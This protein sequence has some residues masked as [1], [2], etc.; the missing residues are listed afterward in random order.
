M[1]GGLASVSVVHDSAMWADGYATLIMALGTERGLAFAHEQGLPAYL[2]TWE[3]AK[4]LRGNAT[5]AIVPM[6][7]GAPAG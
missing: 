1:S 5:T 7:I 4:R 2:L 3:N 6:L